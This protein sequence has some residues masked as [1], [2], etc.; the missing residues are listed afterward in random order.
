MEIVD[1]DRVD[2]LAISGNSKN[3][4]EH[5]FRK[6]Y[7]VLCTYSIGILKDQELAEDTVQEVFIWFWENRSSV[8]VKSSVRAYLFTAVRHKALRVLQK[9]MLEQKHSPKLQEFVEYLL[10]TEYTRDEELEIERIKSVMK[11]LPQ[12]CLKVF[13]MSSL[14]GKKYA[15]IAKELGISVNTV[16]THITKAYRLI[17]T[18]TRTNIPAILYLIFFKL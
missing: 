11:E 9:Q 13:L 15:E 8:E 7:K 3:A 4:F 10:T 12:Q 16:K 14:D 17:R 1:S 5:L 18:K 6:Y 2:F